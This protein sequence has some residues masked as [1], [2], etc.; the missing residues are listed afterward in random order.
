LKVSSPTENARKQFGQAIGQMQ[1]A[2]RLIPFTRRMRLGH[3]GDMFAAS[4]G[5]GE[6]L[7]EACGTIQPKILGPL[8]LKARA[9][10]CQ[11]EKMAAVGHLVDGVPSLDHRILPFGVADEHELSFLFLKAQPQ[12][13]S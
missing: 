12:N 13:P 8:S 2:A 4:R 11:I 6:K 9:E 7:P 1:K 3:A 5:M 10:R